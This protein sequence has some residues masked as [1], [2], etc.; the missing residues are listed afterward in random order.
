MAKSNETRD[1]LRAVALKTPKLKNKLVE[2][3][4]DGGDTVTIEVRQPTIGQRNRMLAAARNTKTDSVD[5]GE[6]TIQCVLHLCYDPESGE[7]LFEEGDAEQL[8]QMPA[9]PGSIVDLLSDEATALMTLGGEGSAKN[10]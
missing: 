2:Y 10:S 8:R 1:R 3:H 4:P 6:F 9:G 5:L 7:R